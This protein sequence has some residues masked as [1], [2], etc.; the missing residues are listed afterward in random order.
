MNYVDALPLIQIFNPA[1][2][3]DANICHDRW[4]D[5]LHANTRRRHE[6][7]KLYK[8]LALCEGNTWE[9]IMLAYYT[10]TIYNT[11]KIYYLRQDDLRNS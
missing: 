6:M 8:W 4:W 1:L 2:A 10:K 11:S 3:S 5:Q 7:E 9:R